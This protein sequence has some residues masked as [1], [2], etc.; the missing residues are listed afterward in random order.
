M[1][2]KDILVVI[3][4]SPAMRPRLEAAVALARAFSAHLTVLCLVPEPFV[5]AMFGVHVPADLLAR[6]LAEAEQAADGALAAALAIGRGQGITTAALRETMPTDQLP[7]VL[8]LHARR[9]DLTILGPPDLDHN[10]LDTVLVAEA[11]FM[12]SGRPALL[13]PWSGKFELP[14]RR[15][16]V[17]WDG[18]REA[19]RAANDA[20]PFYAA[21]QQVSILVVDAPLPDVE[22]RDARGTGIAAHLA[23]HGVNAVVSRR[24]SEGRG[25]GETILAYVQDERADLVVMGGY[26]H[27]RLREVIL[28]GVTRHMLEHATLPIL[29]AH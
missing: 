10:D 17:A 2:L 4:D 18:S 14:P 26:G 27:A 13:V 28:G 7:V 24:T 22:C 16:V 21:A 3:D 20:L 12:D 9:A 6:Q 15:V 29:L 1:P 23:R 19:A 5:P 25:V 11:A 8:A